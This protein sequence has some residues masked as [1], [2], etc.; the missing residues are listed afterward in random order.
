MNC[1]L[2]IHKWAVCAPTADEIS[3]G[4]SATFKLCKHCGEFRVERPAGVR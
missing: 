1:R 4:D 3:N 2:H